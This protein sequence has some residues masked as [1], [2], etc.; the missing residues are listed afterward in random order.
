M[1]ALK[2]SPPPPPFPNKWSS[3]ATPSFSLSFLGGR[4]KGSVLFTNT[5]FRKKKFKKEERISPPS[6]SWVD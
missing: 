1:V 5:V 2:K 4:E 3:S 6:S